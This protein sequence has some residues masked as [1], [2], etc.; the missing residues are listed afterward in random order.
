VAVPIER[1]KKN[2]VVWVTLALSVLVHL[3]LFM[4]TTDLFRIKALS[5]LELALKDEFKPSFRNIPRPP[6]KLKTLDETPR[7]IKEKPV[8]AL[9]PSLPD[10]QPETR[11]TAPVSVADIQGFAA[12]PEGII[13]GV[14][15]GISPAG[16]GFGSANDYYQ[17]VQV[18]I[19]SR[20]Q[21]PPTARQQNQEGRVTVSF[22]IAPDGGV[23][24]LEILKGSRFKALDQA[25]LDAV[26]S[27][28][29]FPRPPSAFF[30]G[31][32]KLQLTLV[33]ELT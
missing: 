31:S 12:V 20:K 10:I 5:T 1:K 33:F 22:V 18:K 6:K 27:C 2:R 9:K 30:Q 15:G 19:E 21:Y 13:T 4:Q 8:L 11:I 32:L 14:A 7:D 25:A 29:P 17:M 16:T 24:G 3:V 28:V 26:K 23:S